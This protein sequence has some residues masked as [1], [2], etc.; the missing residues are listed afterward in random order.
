MS[1]TSKGWWSGVPSEPGWY[2]IETDTPL[3]VLE[4]LPAPA[5]GTKV[6]NIPECLRYNNWLRKNGLAILPPPSGGPFVVYAGEQQNLKNRAREHTYGD[7]GTGCLRLSDYPQ[8]AD[9]AWSFFYLT[10]NSAFPG[11]NGDKALRAL[12]EQ[13]WRGLHGWPLLCKR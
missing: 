13:T 5:Q 9:Y 7:P 4:Q 8:L 3:D 2:Y 6:Y 11:S 1:L 12:G 10:C